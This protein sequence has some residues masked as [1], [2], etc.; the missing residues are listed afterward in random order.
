MVY[1]GFMPSSASFFRSSASIF[2]ETVTYLTK[3][4]TNIIP[5]FVTIEILLPKGIPK[6]S[7]DFSEGSTSQRAR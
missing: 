6:F 1:D 4:T 3:Y 5:Q 7:Q 2:A